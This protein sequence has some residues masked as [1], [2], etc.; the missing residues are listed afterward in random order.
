MAPTQPGE[1]A[2]TPSEPLSPAA[3]APHFPQLEIASQ[4]T[5]AI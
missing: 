5:I 1:T 3:L 4:A 2:Q